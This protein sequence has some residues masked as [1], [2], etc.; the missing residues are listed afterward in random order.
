MAAGRIDDDA[1]VAL[2]FRR[3]GEKLGADALGHLHVDFAEDQ[4]RA[5]FEQRLRDRRGLRLGRLLFLFVVFV[6]VETAQGDLR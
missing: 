3:I 1:D 6:F 2:A 4:H 5:R